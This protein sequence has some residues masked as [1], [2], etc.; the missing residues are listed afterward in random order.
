MTSSL[1]ISSRVSFG[2]YPTYTHY[3]SP[4]PPWVVVSRR[5]S[6]P[7]L[8]GR[9]FRSPERVHDCDKSTFVDRPYGSVLATSSVVPPPLPSPTS[10]RRGT[11]GGPRGRVVLPSRHQT[12]KSWS[13]EVE[14]HTGE[15]DLRGLRGGEWCPLGPL[16]PEE[17]GTTGV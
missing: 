9:T 6:Y 13:V 8:S 4:L 7:S 5:T 10:T 15:S 1:Y 16:N 17:V 3:H 12:V 14:G 2:D 11:W